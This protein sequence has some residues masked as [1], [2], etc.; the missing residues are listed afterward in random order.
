MR[1]RDIMKDADTVDSDTTLQKA[2]GLMAQNNIGCLLVL[3]D[4]EVKGIITERDVIKQV[5]KDSRSL[6]HPVSD[7]MSRKLVTADADMDIDEAAVIM[8]KNGIKKL[9]VTVDDK[10][11]GIV[12]QTD[13]IA[14]AGDFNDFSVL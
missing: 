10:I 3:V 6:E 8:K 9:P 14:N 13:L 5:G 11:E 7:Y 2:A 1:L 12:T 4:G